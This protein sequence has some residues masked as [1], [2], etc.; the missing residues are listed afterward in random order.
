MHMINISHVI[1][2][3]FL[4]KIRKLY[5]PGNIKFVIKSV[6]G[7]LFVFDFDFNLSFLWG[8]SSF[9]FISFFKNIFARVGGPI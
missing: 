5:V 4:I 7:F 9:I 3:I 2:S 8:L 1:F 6:A